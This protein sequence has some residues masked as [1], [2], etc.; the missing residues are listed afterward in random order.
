[1]CVNWGKNL[2]IQR[3][4][5]VWSAGKSMGK[6]RRPQIGRDNEKKSKKMDLKKIGSDIRRWMTSK[7]INKNPGCDKLYPIFIKKIM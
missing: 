7:R 1:M 5:P 2:Q 6:F 4:F 3:L